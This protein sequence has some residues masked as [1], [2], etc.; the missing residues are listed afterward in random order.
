MYPIVTKG[1]WLSAVNPT[2]R[3][4]LADRVSQLVNE[5]KT[6]GVLKKVDIDESG[7]YYAYRFWS[8]TATAQAWIDYC[9]IIPTDQMSTISIV[10]ASEVA[11]L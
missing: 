5:S 7:S 9:A 1:T 8:D 2:L 6:D 10:D 4:T 11:D 3:G